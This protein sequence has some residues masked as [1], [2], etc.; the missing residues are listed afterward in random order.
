MALLFFTEYKSVTSPAWVITIQSFAFLLC[1]INGYIALNELRKR[2]GTGIHYKSKSLRDLSSLV[3]F[4]GFIY[5]LCQL[6]QFFD[7]FC[8]FV[9]AFSTVLSWYQMAFVN[10]YQLR[11]LYA[12]VTIFKGYPVPLLIFMAIF[13]VVICTAAAVFCALYFSCIRSHCNLDEQYYFHAK[14]WFME[15]DAVAWIASTTICVS[16]LFDLITLLLFVCKIRAVTRLVDT[17]D[18]RHNTLLR[19]RREMERIIMLTLLYQ[20]YGGLI[21][22]S[23]PILGTYV[24]IIAYGQPTFFSLSI[25]LMQPHNSDEYRKTARILTFCI[26]CYRDAIKNH[27]SYFKV[28]GTT[29]ELTKALVVR[30]SVTAMNLFSMDVP[31]SRMYQSPG[32]IS[33]QSSLDTNF[34]LKSSPLPEK[35]SVDTVSFRRA[36]SMLNDFTFDESS[37]NFNFGVYLEYWR[38]DRRNSVSPKY[39]TLREELTMNR[40]ATIRA[41]QYEELKRESEKIKENRLFMAR[42]IGAMN[43]ICGIAPGSMMTLE[44]MICIKL[45]TDFTDIQFIFKKQCRKLHEDEPLE[46]VIHRNKEI[47]HWCRL[48]K[49]VIMFYGSSMSPSDVVYCGLNGRLLFRSLHQRFECPLSTTKRKLVAEQFAQRD[50]KGVILTLKRA[51]PKCR[52]FDVAPFTVFKN[53]EERVF[54]GSTLKIIDISIGTKSLK[55]YIKA[56]RMLEQIVNGFLIDYAEQ[57]VAVLISFLHQVVAL[58]VIDALRNHVLSGSFQNNLEQEEYDTDAVLADLEDVEDS[59]IIDSAGGEGAVVLKLIQETQG[60]S[61]QHHLQCLHIDC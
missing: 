22:F 46:N 2:R 39:S 29:T 59:N 17:D 3:I 36:T 19:I 5:S 10:L 4:S 34:S 14:G 24:F 23:W 7:G 26:C 13:N 45:Y 20:I 53:E 35:S 32:I 18:S 15:G 57:S 52:Y 1:A 12:M 50:Q 37:N 58:S 30:N 9:S 60:T 16:A 42:N 31:P 61:L 33:N 47:A 56:L 55:R 38:R 51:S 54:A 41:A 25:W 48:L 27:I 6:L 40:H 8:Y 49:E 43:A 44:H 21:M 28:S 11:R